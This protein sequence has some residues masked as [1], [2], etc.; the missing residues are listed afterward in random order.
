VSRAALLR[1]SVL[2]AVLVAVGLSS[3]AAG[4]AAGATPPSRC[5]LTGG[6]G[7]PNPAHVG[8]DV[9]ATVSVLSSHG[10]CD[11][12]VTVIGGGWPLCT[13]D[14][15]G[16]GGC[17]VTFGAFPGLSTVTAKLTTGQSLVLGTFTVLSST[18]VPHASSTVTRRTVTTSA[19]A[20]RAAASSAAA[21]SR[22]AASASA[23]R[24]ASR[25][26]ASKV[27][28]N[29]AFPSDTE[30]PTTAPVTEASPSDTASASGF[31]VNVRTNPSGGSSIPAGPLLLA[32]VILA[33]FVAAAG[34]LIYTHTHDEIGP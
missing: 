23:S 6:I 12:T 3:L 19:S 29:T 4:T 8:D 20:S 10:T 33:G 34:R 24:S 14:V 17:S 7:G 9:S 28:T 18:P 31:A 25:S 30:T 22:G 16:S 11:A 21:A 15:F 27:V 1:S 2:G 32:L 26:H 13:D 5:A